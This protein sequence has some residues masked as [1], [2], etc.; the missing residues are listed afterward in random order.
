MRIYGSTMSPYVRKVLV[1]CA[2][3]EI[4]VE[5]VPV[6]VGS[7]DEGFRAASPFGKMPAMVDGDFSLADSSA[8]VHYLEAKHPLPVLIPREA[9]AK[10]LT[11]WW[12]EFG[13]TILMPCAGKMFFNR[14]VA[15][16][17]LKREGDLAAAERAELEELPPL[18]DFLEQR[19]TG[20]SYLVGESLTLG[21]IAVASP[22]AN[23]A[24]AG[25]KIGSER[26]NLRDYLERMQ[27]RPSFA[28]ILARERGYFVR[29]REKEGK[30]EARPSTVAAG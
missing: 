18:L 27:E 19:L 16:M 9:R 3:K 28:P 14:V 6:G 26:P 24:Y 25:V 30:A 4:E 10:G 12:E 23:L 1:C 5:S 2:E 11:I 21:D 20:K 17:F 29:L 15:P 13:D 22:L 8:I 7:K